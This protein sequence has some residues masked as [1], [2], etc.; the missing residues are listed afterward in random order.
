[1][2]VPVRLG[3][4]VLLLFLLLA[5]PEPAEAAGVPQASAI[6][7][8]ASGQRTRATVELD[9]PVSFRTFTVG[10]P[11]RLIV[12]LP[13]ID[14]KV[15]S[16]TGRRPGGLVVAQRHG[17]FSPGRSR[18]VLDL[19][20][21]FKVVAQA[22]LPPAPGT[23][24]YRLV[25]DLEPLFPI[26]PDTT[27]RMAA[28]PPGPPPA[29]PL[30]RPHDVPAAP[31]E[32][33][34]AALVAAEPEPAAL[35]PVAPNPVRV[36]AATP[37][38]PDP[39]AA[40]P[41]VPDLAPRSPSAMEP[42]PN[43]AD[44]Q[45]ALAVPPP[46]TALS[47]PGSLPVIVIDPG[48]GGV[49][50]G[51]IGVGGVREKVIV[52][53]MAHALR[54]LLTGSGRYRVVLTREDDSFLRLRERIARSREAQG[55]L[56]ISLHA[57]S[58]RLGAQRGSA[59]YTLSETASDEE[60]GRLASKENKSDIL[61]DTDLSHHD[62]VVTSILI[63][64]AQR[65]TNNRSIGFA[66]LLAEELAAVT[67]LV[68]RHQRFAGFAVLKSPDTPSVLLELG[69]L[70]NRDDAHNLSQPGYRAK[71]AGAVLKALD[72]QFGWPGQ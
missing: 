6:R 28:A 53:E 12:D 39:P 65:E 31:V 23:R 52:L 2:E 24:L 29:V 67:P 33:P 51:A 49:D 38:I 4:A 7:F 5:P 66:D 62:P 59:V 72:R 32:E 43:A 26:V 63:D 64:L 20:A 61:A 50:P 25:I 46:P 15:R 34:V 37:S 42:D 10:N 1:M 8:A 35:P 16:D 19:A 55:D 13:E 18:L 57:D 48:H 40:S 14:W 54:D 69:Y 47:Q 17:L 21:P 22:L 27:T 30:R 70:S 44:A 9:R 60:A 3:L 45:V 58:L 56:F 71:L 41:L 11:Q 36:A 68:H